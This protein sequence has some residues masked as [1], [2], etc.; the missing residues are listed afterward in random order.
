MADVAHI[1]VVSG[2]VAI[3]FSVLSRGENDLEKAKNYGRIS[4]YVN[5]AA[6]ALGI[7]SIIIVVILVVVYWQMIDNAS[8]QTRDNESG[9]WG[10]W[11]GRDWIDGCPPT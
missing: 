9:C 4:L 2:I 8:G 7:L 1:V 5:I 11:E 10:Y 6:L 3:I